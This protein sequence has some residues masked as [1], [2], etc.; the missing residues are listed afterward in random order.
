MLELAGV[1]LLAATSRPV[2]EVAAQSRRVFQRGQRFRILGP[3]D[4]LL[5]GDEVNVGQGQDGIEELEEPFLSVRPAEEPGG[6]EEEREGCLRLGVVIEE[7]LGEDLLDGRDVLVVEASVSHGT[8][9]SSD[10]LEDGHGDLPHVW[11]GEDR[12][13]FYSAGVRE[14]VV[15]RVR[16]RWGGGRHRGVVVQTVP[17][18]IFYSQYRIV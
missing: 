2:D 5:T 13:G 7:V 3:V 9:S 17:K 8:G 14:L 18:K 11:M 10:V 15:E 6:V 1:L 4:Q 12:A 16:P